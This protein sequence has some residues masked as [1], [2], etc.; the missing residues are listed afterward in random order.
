M[1][2]VSDAEGAELEPVDI[3]ELLRFDDIAAPKPVSPQEA[4][5][6]E[7]RFH[8]VIAL[9]EAGLEYGRY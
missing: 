3:G 2:P 6:F 1:R 9:Y 8:T 5:N 7:R 4:A